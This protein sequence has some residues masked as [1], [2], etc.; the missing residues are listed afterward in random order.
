MFH[1]R[2]CSTTV[3]D[4]LMNLDDLA[5][6]M[7]RHPEIESITITEI[8]ETTLT[9]DMTPAMVEQLQ[10]SELWWFE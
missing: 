10:Q 7:E 4:G 3:Y 6:W 2:E 1:F 5:E 8:V 9:P